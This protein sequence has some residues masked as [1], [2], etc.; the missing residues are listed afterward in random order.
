MLCA[1]CS[2]RQQP[3]VVAVPRIVRVTPPAH[4][5]ADTPAPDCRDARTNGDL[6]QCVQDYRSALRQCNADKAAIRAGMEG[7]P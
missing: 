4:L 3:E 7:R 5:L 6:L 2:G 1:A